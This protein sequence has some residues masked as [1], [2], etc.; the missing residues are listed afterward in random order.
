M[1]LAPLLCL[2]LLAACLPSPGADVSMGGNRSVIPDV[3]RPPAEIARFGLVPGK[4]PTRGN[5]E[6]AREFLDLSFELESGRH[7]P[8]FTRFE[9]PVTLRL[10]GPVPS[11]AATDL[12][13]LLQ[14]LRSEAGIDIRETDAG[15]AAI[16]VEFMPRST[17]RATYANV[18]CFVEPRVGS[19]AEFRSARHTGQLDWT[20]LTRRERV[21]IFLPSDAPP[22]E[23]RD[24]LH[25][26]L[27]QALGPLNDLYQLTDSVFNDDNF[28]TSLTGYDMLILRT[29]YAPE[30]RSGMR[31]E[32]VAARLPGILARINPGG[33]QAH[34]IPASQ[35]TSQLWASR[36]RHALGEQGSPRERF[37][38]AR[39]ALSQA[40]AEGWTDGRLAF[41]HFVLGRQALADD[42]ALARDA[43]RHAARIYRR[44]PGGAIHAAHA[45]MQ[46]AAHA[47]AR[48][49]ARTARDIA[50]RITPV[51]S[52]SEN[53]ALMATLLLL[54]AE[55][56]DMLGD[57]D[58][59]RAL[60]MDSRG[61]ARYG[62]GSD[63]IVT[64]RMREIAALAQRD[65]G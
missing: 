26:E 13:R 18:A 42:P 10:Q 11:A 57:H 43:L 39:Q 21:A 31:R 44:L 25:E 6:I 55:A 29:Y 58:M 14:R 1:R 62:F 23:V 61:W 8:V 56:A 64:E 30:L 28:H 34:A 38:A 51:A 41:S 22:Q 17:I 7:L 49:D 65:R 47:L 5:A 9:G 50:T 60:R 12:S 3:V 45:D 19:W 27:A 40:H 24:C 32:E 36:I 46:L 33:G 59:A 52:Q 15:E 35:P 2:G 20:T 4:R 53:A 16:T 54:R 63:A 48:G 37:A